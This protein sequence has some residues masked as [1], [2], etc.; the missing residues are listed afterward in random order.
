MR[1]KKLL[2]AFLASVL[3]LPFVVACDNGGKESQK[4]FG[5][6]GYWAGDFPQ[7]FLSLAGEEAAPSGIYFYRQSNKGGFGKLFNRGAVYGTLELLTE[8]RE[9]SWTV[10]GD[11]FRFSFK[12]PVAVSSDSSV[13]A[14]VV[15]EYKRANCELILL[16]GGNTLKIVA[17][18]LE[19]KRHCDF[20]LTRITGDFS[21]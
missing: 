17:Y 16:D 14:N 18:D 2:T 15:N 7:E 6:I 19:G 10:M 4:E 20:T 21:F 11:R 5:F 12:H 3:M 8:V 13:D 9:F 1:K